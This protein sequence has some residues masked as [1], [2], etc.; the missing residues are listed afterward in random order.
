MIIAYVTDTFY[1][2]IKGGAERYFYE[3]STRLA[4][5]GHEV[6][7]F[8]TKWW[9]GKDDIE[10]EGVL[11]HGVTDYKRRHVGSRRWLLQ[12]LDFGLSVAP[13][14]ALGEFDI[15]DCNQTPYFH[16]FSA[17]IISMIKNSRFVITWQEVWGDYWYEYAGWFVGFVGKLM[18]RILAHLPNLII[19]DADKVKE[20]LIALGIPSEKVRVIYD[21]IDVDAFRKA[22]PSEE[23]LDIVFLG[24]LMSYKNV[25]I[26][27][28][29]TKILIKQFPDIRLGIIGDGPDAPKLKALVN[30]LG[31]EKHVKF[32]GFI[33]D[34]LKVV[35]ILKA[36]KVFV[37]LS[38][39]EGS[40]IV[41][42]EANAA[43]L[44]V[45]ALDHPRGVS[46]H[47]ICEG[48]NGL[49]VK[50]LDPKLVAERVCVLLKDE[51]LLFKMKKNALKMAK[52]YSWDKTA[53]EVEKTYRYLLER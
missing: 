47:L 38:T 22:R 49:W 35:S 33:D 41:V 23:E 19:T 17:K 7:V 39:Q 6:H 24:R 1:P 11:L 32:Y 28:K 18:E 10:Y 46:K 20:G 48:Y 8:C 25:D 34:F 4:K 30:K 43:G 53:S 26:L 15:I 14:V 3:V 42:Q 51:D 2:F 50:K 5:R 16:C 44:P 12:P 40:G 9:S 52:N 21:G 13:K 45:V 36:A 27:I 37:H 29:A 31:I